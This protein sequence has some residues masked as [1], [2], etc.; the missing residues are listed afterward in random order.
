QAIKEK[1]VEKYFGNS[2]GLLSEA[3]ENEFGPIIDKFESLV[4]TIN[5][6]AVNKSY[7]ALH[8]ESGGVKIKILLSHTHNHNTPEP[9]LP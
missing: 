3:K 8:Q 9:S 2:N 5:Q 6:K 7:A 4:K 1:L